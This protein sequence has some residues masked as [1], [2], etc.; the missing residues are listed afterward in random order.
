[1]IHVCKEEKAG[2]PRTPSRSSNAVRRYHVSAMC[3]SLDGSQNRAIVRIAAT[4]GQGPIGVPLAVLAS[5]EPLEKHRFPAVLFDP[6]I[7]AW[8]DENRIATGKVVTTAALIAN[9]P[10]H[11]RQ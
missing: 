3:S 8:Q 4:S 1:M 9:H 2:A 5:F 11:A 10:R 7:T 6:S